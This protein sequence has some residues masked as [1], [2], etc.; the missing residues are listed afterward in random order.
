MPGCHHSIKD[1]NS[2]F[3]GQN[4]HHFAADTFKCIF[5]NENFCNLIIISLKFIPKLPINNSPALVQIM[6]WRP[7]S[8]RPPRRPLSDCFEQAQNFTA[9]MASM[10]MSERPKC[11]P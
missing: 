2:S 9:I 1:I 8:D 6:A 11:D 3:L 7:V 5:V 10:A 4:G